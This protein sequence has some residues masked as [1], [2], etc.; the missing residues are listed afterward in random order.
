MASALI[1]VLAFLAGAA[2]SAWGQQGIYTCVDA[3]GKRLTS[4][5]PHMEC[6]DREQ[7]ELN[8]SGTVRRIVPPSMTAVER[9][10]QDER[11]RR[12]ADERQRQG[13]DRRLQRALLA[14]YPNPEVHEAEREKALRMQQDA[15]D[16]TQRRVTE[17]REQRRKL[18]AESASY[19]SPGEWPARLRREFDDNDQQAESQQRQVAAQEDELKRLTRRFDE[20]LAR[21]KLMWAQVQVPTASATPAAAPL[22]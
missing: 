14:R 6:L 2:G 5:R 13:E 8:S 17:L 20:E 16:A 21:L 19:K 12:T 4:D 3:R 11:D 7:R 1:P 22:R 15:L 9:A 10:A 18:E